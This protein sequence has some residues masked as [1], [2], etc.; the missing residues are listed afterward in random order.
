MI[1]KCSKPVFNFIH[2]SMDRDGL[3]GQSHLHSLPLIC[4]KLFGHRQF[5]VDSVDVVIAFSVVV[6]AAGGPRAE[7]GFLLSRR[8]G[9]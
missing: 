5:G 8:V 3:D 6:M 7:F 2:I 4:V 1:E 9:S